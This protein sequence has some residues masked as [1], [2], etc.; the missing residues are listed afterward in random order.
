ML[1]GT[2]KITGGTGKFKGIQGQG[3]F[4]CTTLNDKGQYTCTQQFDYSLTAVPSK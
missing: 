3:P 2:N 1:D 4:H